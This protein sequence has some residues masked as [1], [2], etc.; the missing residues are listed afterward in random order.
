MPI[1]MVIGVV[2]I[3]WMVVKAWTSI[4]DAPLALEPV[5][6][7]DPSTIPPVGVAVTGTEPGP[8]CIPPL[9]PPPVRYAIP[10][11]KIGT[12]L[13]LAGT[14]TCPKIVRPVV[15]WVNWGV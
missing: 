5:G 10:P 2:P 13:M 6:L 12:A 15:I 1:G 9:A 14:G 8:N 4:T 11:G 7:R 3:L